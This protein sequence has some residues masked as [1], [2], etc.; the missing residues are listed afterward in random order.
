LAAAF[1]RVAFA[2]AVFAALVLFA[3]FVAFVAVAISVD[4][5][6]SAGGAVAQVGEFSRAMYPNMCL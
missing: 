5:S 1:V 3:V 6:C 2:F 4:L